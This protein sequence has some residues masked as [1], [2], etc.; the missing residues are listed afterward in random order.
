MMTLPAIKGA[1]STKLNNAQTDSIMLIPSASKNKELAKAFLRFICSEERMVEFTKSNGVMRPFDY[2]P[3]EIASDYEWSVFQRDAI[4]LYT[5]NTNFFQYSKNKSP[6]Y[7]FKGLTPY[8]PSMSTIFSDLL[9]KTPAAT[10]KGALD[11]VDQRWANW[12]LDLGLV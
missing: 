11:Y 5:E 12:K 6:F 8:Q 4:S 2:N 10:A 7:V 9:E 3:L 1:R